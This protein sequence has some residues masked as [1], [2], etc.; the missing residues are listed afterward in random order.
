M[1]STTKY[2]PVPTYTVFPWGLQTPAQFTPGLVILRIGRKRQEEAC[3]SPSASPPPLPPTSGHS[4]PSSPTPLPPSSG[5]SSPASPPALPTVSPHKAPKTYLGRTR[6]RRCPPS[7]R[8]PHSV[9]P[10]PARLPARRKKEEKCCGRWNYIKCVSFFP[11]SGSRC[12]ACKSPK[13]MDCHTCL[14]PQ[15]KQG[16]FLQ[17]S[18]R[19]IVCG[20]GVLIL[21]M[22]LFR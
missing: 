10:S 21:R 4:P 1:P 20:W 3:P 22:L 16:R 8:S 14:N 15:K 19:K 7:G 6:R 18:N 13:C 11:F 12:L 2:Q 5:T 17:N 9:L